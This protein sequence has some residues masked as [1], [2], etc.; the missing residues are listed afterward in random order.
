MSKTSLFV[1]LK[2]RQVYRVAVAYAAVGWLLVEIT[3]QVFP[4]FHI[5]DWA[6]QLVVLLIVI[7][8]PIAVVLAWAFEMTPEGVRRTQSA[9]SPQARSPGQRRHVGRK[10]DFVIITVLAIAVAGL[11][12]RQFGPHASAPNGLAAAKLGKSIAVLPF[13][14]L[15]SDK[16]NAYFADGIQDEILTSLAKIG[17]LKVISRTSTRSYGSRPDNVPQIA[18]ELGVATILE[19][20]VQRSGKDVLINVR[21]IDARTDSHLWANTYQRTLDNVFGVEGEVAGRIAEALKAKLTPAETAR[22]ADKPT[23]NVAAYDLFLRAEYLANKGIVNYDTTSFKPA[24]ALYQ[25]AVA[26]DPGFALA[27]ARMSI[28]QSWLDHFGGGGMDQQQLRADARANAERAAKLQPGLADTQL[29]LGYADYYGRGDYE[30][31]L[32]SFAKALKARPNDAGAMLASA[33]VLRRQGHYAAAIAQLQAAM[34]RD[35]RNT[36]YA[37]ELG[38][39]E[40]AAG[41][42]GKAGRMFQRALALDPDNVPAKN[43]YSWLVVLSTGD[44]PRAL[45]QVQGDNPQLQ[46]QRVF[47]LTAQRHYRA[48]IALLQGIPDTPDTFNIETYGPKAYQLANLYRLA[49]DSARARPLYEQVLPWLSGQFAAHAGSPINLSYLW[50]L[51]AGVQLGLG[52]TDAAL[53]SLA[54]AQALLLQSR[55][56]MVGPAAME[57]IAARYAEAGRA[58]L[59]VPAIEAHF[60]TPGAPAYYSPLMLWLDPAWDP[61]RKDPRFQALLKK[62]AD[63]APANLPA[64][65]GNA[66]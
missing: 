20:S 45:A 53:D 9:D 28:V 8:F 10:L 40:M 30:V 1:E 65:T 58:D 24:I 57:F 38:S 43:W 27:L 51:R 60:A 33:Y 35:P 36:S 61:I 62:Y 52:Q 66:P 32:K 42:Y 16:D 14:N 19:G 54:R 26:A 39:T 29:A 12:W 18:S 31:A 5:P 13:E 4:V 22:V 55:D 3:T 44:F 47:L 48:A 41:R 2:R 21:L 64:A 37:L 56:H 23:R 59:A 50:S 15:S 11:A 6:A 49:G 25:Q 34:E 63:Q 46:A 17:E 7:G